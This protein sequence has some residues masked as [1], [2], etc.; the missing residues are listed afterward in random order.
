VIL[1]VTQTREPQRRNNGAK[2]TALQ[3]DRINTQV[4]TGYLEVA[5]RQAL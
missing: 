1:N 2:L 4:A 3:P 5:R